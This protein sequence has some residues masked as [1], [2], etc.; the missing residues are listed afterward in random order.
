MASKEELFETLFEQMKQVSPSERFASGAVFDIVRQCHEDFEKTI[1]SEDAMALKVFF[2]KAYIAFCK[3]P[4]IVNF[5]PELVN[6]NNNDTDP[7]VWNTDIFNL[8]DGSAAALCYM[9]V[10]QE[11]I[12]ARIIGIILGSKGD[13]YYYCML[14]KD[15]SM[16]SEIK[17][18]N[19]MRGIATIGTVNGRGFD[20]M[21]SFLDSIR[22]D[23]CAD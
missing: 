4:Q 14:N 11:T 12:E 6:A 1:L 5:P 2:I 16:A 21:H 23:Y 10:S 9:P 8:E 22:S 13:G 3:N 18:N 19:A 20:L 15:E 7:R 17:K